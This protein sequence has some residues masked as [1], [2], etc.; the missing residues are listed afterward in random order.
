MLQYSLRWV[1]SKLDKVDFQ[2][3]TLEQNL[4]I[5]GLRLDKLKIEKVLTP[6]EQKEID[7]LIDLLR[8]NS[9]KLAKLLSIKAFSDFPS[10]TSVSFI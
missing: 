3:A 1:N 7:K 6:E 9:K 5:L 10:Q 2:I 4:F 8:I